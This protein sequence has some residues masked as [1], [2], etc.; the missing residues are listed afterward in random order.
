MMYWV[1]H[2]VVCTLSVAITLVKCWPQV[3]DD[4]ITARW[5]EW[6]LFRRGR[7]SVLRWRLWTWRVRTIALVISLSRSISTT[8]LSLCLVFF[9]AGG[10]TGSLSSNLQEIS[11]SLWKT[12]LIRFWTADCRRSFTFQCLNTEQLF[13]SVHF[14][15]VLAVLWFL[16]LSKNQGYRLKAV[17]KKCDFSHELENVQGWC[18]SEFVWQRVPCCRSGVWESTLSEPCR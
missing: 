16:M 7:T 4:R 12:S 14:V 6:R 10:V 17:L 1:A 11:W 15:I 3:W 8:M 5:R 18:S 9:L 2:C 13:T